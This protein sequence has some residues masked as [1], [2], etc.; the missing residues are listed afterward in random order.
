M[1]KKIRITLISSL[2]VT[3]G[4]FSNV[5]AATHNVN[6]MANR[7]PITIKNY[8]TNMTINQNKF[9]N[10]PPI[11]SNLS[12]NKLIKSNLFNNNDMLPDS[13]DNST[14]PYFP[15]IGDQ[16]DLG[17]CSVFS[18]IYYQ[19]SFMESQSHS[20]K[21]LFSPRLTYDLYNAGNNNSGLS[22]Q[23]IYASLKEFGA[24]LQSDFPYIKESLPI[25][26]YTAWPTNEAIWEKALK[27][28]ISDFIPYDIN[29]GRD[30]NKTMITDYTD[31]SLANVKRALNTGYVLTYQSNIYG[32]HYKTGSNGQDICYAVDNSNPAG[33]HG[34][35]MVGYND[36]IWVDINGNGKEDPGERG[37]FKVVNSWGTGWE[38][39]GFGWIAY[40]ALNKV[41][42][43]NN[44]P[45][46]NNRMMAFEDS[47]N[48]RSN[49]VYAMT[50][51]NGDYIPKYLLKFTAKTSNR[52]N[53]NL[54]VFVTDKKTGD[55]KLYRSSIFDYGIGGNYAFDGTTIP[56]DASFAIDVT[57][58]ITINSDPKQ[59]TLKVS[60]N[61]GD[62]IR[63]IT[64]LSTN[65]GVTVEAPNTVS[66]SS[67]PVMIQLN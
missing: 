29:D 37:A 6:S 11:K 65:D 31:A 41:S 43:V 12:R 40:D 32:W 60:G 26:N 46:I 67:T 50:T 2:I 36:N 62:E 27:Y 54:V 61:N 52:G 47:F 38:N 34:M 24:P 39:N 58:D 1:N 33:L 57:N 55:T 16:G 51:E 20:Q 10:L 17:D 49:F 22:F 18:T 53:F 4:C 23:S 42:S 59:V 14:L 66:L 48:H 64:L 5:F 8:N 9:K 25:T 3:F 30:P 45:S 35:T 15:A 19:M 21:L 63:N 28:K 13:V 56:C 7:S 44:A